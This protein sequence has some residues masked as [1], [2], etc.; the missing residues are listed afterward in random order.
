MSVR[1]T[2][3]LFGAV[4]V[5]WFFACAAV[6]PKCQRNVEETFRQVHENIIGCS[7]EPQM[8]TADDIF[9]SKLDERGIEYAVSQEGLYEVQLDDQTVTVSLDNLRRNYDRDGDADAIVRFVARLDAD[10][11][12]ETPSW[13]DVRPYVRYSLEPSDYET[14]LDDA[15][16]NAVSDELNQVFVYTSPDG[17]RITWINDSMLEAWGVTRE[18]VVRQAEENM[19]AIIAD[20]NFEVEDVQG[21]QLG[22]ISTN[23]TSF[24]ASLILSPAFRDLVSPTHGWPVYVVAPCRDFAYVVRHDNREFL[25]RLGRVVINEYRKSGYPITTDVLQVSDD[26]IISIG[27]FS[28]SE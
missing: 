21:Y 16:F 4:C 8:Q 27:G 28:E 19:S 22:M 2:I 6:I 15:L 17:Y 23:E 3:W 13:D 25:G 9:C 26:G 11:F 18:Q 20:T 10:F 5:V 12:S 14:G 24:K 7:K 1:L